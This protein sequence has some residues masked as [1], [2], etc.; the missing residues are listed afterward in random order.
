MEDL[1]VSSSWGIRRLGVQVVQDGTQ[2]D[3]FDP[4]YLLDEPDEVVMLVEETQSSIQNYLALV[5]LAEEKEQPGDS[6]VFLVRKVADTISMKW[7]VERIPKG[8][9]VSITV[10]DVRVSVHQMMIDPHALRAKM[11]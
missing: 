10:G 8:G 5:M 2:A 11:W 7:P 4:G 3:V 1:R 9:I 6:G